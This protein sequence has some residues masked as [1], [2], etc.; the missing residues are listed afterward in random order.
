MSI[1]DVKFYG[2][3]FRYKLEFSGVRIFARKED[4][5]ITPGFDNSFFE[6][7]VVKEYQGKNDVL[8]LAFENG[9]EAYETLKFPY[10]FWD[11]EDN[12]WRES[13]DTTTPEEF[14][15]AYLNRNKN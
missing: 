7:T 4:V 2:V 14:M 8:K 5:H 12:V 9:E 13:K 3:Y 1:Y 11:V 15:K 10:L 6:V